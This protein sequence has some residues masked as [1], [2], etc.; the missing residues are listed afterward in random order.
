MNERKLRQLGVL[1]NQDN[2]NSVESEDGVSEE[3]MD[4]YLL[5]EQQNSMPPAS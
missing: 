1:T 2:D 4:E 3:L 5:S